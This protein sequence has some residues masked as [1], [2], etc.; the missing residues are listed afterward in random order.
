[1]SNP[2]TKLNSTDVGMCPHGNYK[3]SCTTC[4]LEKEIGREVS[5]NQVRRTEIIAREKNKRSSFLEKFVKGGIDAGDILRENARLA[6]LFE[7][8]GDAKTTME[9]LNKM[10][11]KIEAK[12]ESE[13]AKNKTDQIWKKYTGITESGEWPS[14]IDSEERY[15]KGQK[16]TEEIFNYDRKHVKPLI[17]SRAS[18]G[19]LFD[20]YAEVAEEEAKIKLLEKLSSG[21][22]SIIDDLNNMMR[23]EKISEKISEEEISKLITDARESIIEKKKKAQATILS[24]DFSAL[25]EKEIQEIME[26]SKSI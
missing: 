11:A 14:G 24:T 23:N 9:I 7:K 20:K 26:T 19:N 13:Y 15:R 8:M 10:I 17:N 12:L 5:N 1:M 4:E 3:D 6:E 16:A 25:T 21:D 2:E 18:I 22:Q